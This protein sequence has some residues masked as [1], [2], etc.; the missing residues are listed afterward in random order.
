MDE[1]KNK[2]KELFKSEDMDLFIGYEEGTQTPRP[3][4]AASAEEAGKL[5][6]NDKCT[7]N[8]AVYLTRKDLVE[9][10]KQGFSHHTI[11]SKAYPVYW[12]KTN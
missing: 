5:I 2:I 11:P 9:V 8:L 3:C 10:R 7:G 4:F 6:F 1:L 12:Q